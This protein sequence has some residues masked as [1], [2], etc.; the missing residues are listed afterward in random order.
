MGAPATVDTDRVSL[1][2]FCVNST[3]TIAKGQ[4]EFPALVKRAE[5]GELA[6]VTR[7]DKPVAYVI[8][9]ERMEAM[10]ETMELL[11]NPEFMRAFEAD[12]SGKTAYHRLEAIA[13]D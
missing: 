6:V 13:E 9:A 11:A 7:H 10:L 5:K 4:R 2:T 1:L 12:R 8:S 3:Y